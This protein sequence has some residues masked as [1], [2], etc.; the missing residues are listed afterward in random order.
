MKSISQ[1]R[2]LPLIASLFLFIISF[3]LGGYQVTSTG[4]N[5][6]SQIQV[7]YGSYAF[8]TL[9]AATGLILFA[10]CFNIAI[11]GPAVG[12]RRA[13]IGSALTSSGLTIAL[14]SS[15]V[16][17]IQDTDYATRCANECGQAL[18]RSYLQIGQDLSIGIVLGAILTAIGLWLLIRTISLHRKASHSREKLRVVEP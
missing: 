15:V 1:L 7:P 8:P 5:G 12:L 13:V 18:T 14:F 10:L 17:W 16:L 11:R 6:L 2:I 4:Q 3:F 9:A